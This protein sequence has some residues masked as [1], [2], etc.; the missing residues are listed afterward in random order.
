VTDAVPTPGP[1]DRS[2]PA[3]GSGSPQL[4][5]DPDIENPGAGSQSAQPRVLAAVSAGG[6]LGAV[7][8][9]GVGS[10]W[11]SS[12]GFAWSTFVVNVSGCLLIGLVVVVTTERQKGHPL[13]RPFLATG[14]LGGFTTFSTYTVEAHRLLLDGRA[15]TALGYLG[16]TLASAVLAAAL[17]LRLGRRLTGDPV[18]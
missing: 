18:R 5:V 10:A 15:G 7:A 3:V 2:P 8:R 17:G 4:P 6:L 12:A 14:V 1:P 9:Y 16:A 11:P 13:L